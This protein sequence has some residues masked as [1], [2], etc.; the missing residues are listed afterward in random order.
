MLTVTQL[1]EKRN[2]IS[3]NGI[4]LYKNELYKIHY[5][6]LYMYQLGKSILISYLSINIIS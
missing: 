5:Y 6:I 1:M 2:I 3:L 4:I